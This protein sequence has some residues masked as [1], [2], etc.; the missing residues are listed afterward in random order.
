MLTRIYLFFDWIISSS[1]YCSTRASRMC[2][3]YSTKDPVSFGRKSFFNT[4]PLHTL[5]ILY[6]SLVI[7]FSR[8][9]NLAEMVNPYYHSFEDFIWCIIITMGTIGYGDHY[10][11]A[12][13]GRLIAFLAAL[14]G[15]IWNS[16]LILTLS[17]YLS[18][19]SS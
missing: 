17:Q 18:M 16:L 8:M 4:Y 9:L 14:S 12:Y 10:P 11:S 5:L 7:V 6:V 3:M 2:R 15:I 1:I 19:S 13:I